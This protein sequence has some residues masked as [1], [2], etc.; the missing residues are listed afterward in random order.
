MANS[1]THDA[2]EPTGRMRFGDIVLDDNRISLAAKGVFAVI[3]FLGGACTLTEV[4]AHCSD[5]GGL[6]PTL[7]EL[8]KR[9]YVSVHENVITVRDAA[10]FGSPD[11]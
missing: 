7:E 5:E 9:G 1:S 8:V 10:D 11:A 6:E 4:A 3:G 2:G